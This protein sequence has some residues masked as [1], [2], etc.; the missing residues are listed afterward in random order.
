MC[1]DIAPNTENRVIT[2]ETIEEFNQSLFGLVTLYCARRD[3]I[4]TFIDAY[5]KKY[6]ISEEEVEA[7]HEEMKN[8]SEDHAIITDCSVK[9]EIV[10]TD[11]YVPM[12][13]DFGNFTGSFGRDHPPNAKY[14]KGCPVCNR[15]T[16]HEKPVE[17]Q[18][19]NDIFWKVTKCLRCGQKWRY[20]GD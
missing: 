16:A 20:I 10:T 8:F 17:K 15:W 13:E 19:E 14:V 12:R 18:F 5:N 6:Q 3:A 7:F 9:I 4:M 2:Y 11:E 1:F